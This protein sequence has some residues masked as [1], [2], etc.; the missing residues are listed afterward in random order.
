MIADNLAFIVPLCFGNHHF[1][2]GGGGIAVYARDKKLF[3]GLVAVGGVLHH[4]SES[5]QV[6]FG[7][8]GIGGLFW[9]LCI[10]EGV[11]EPATHIPYLA[12][13]H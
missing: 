7:V 11:V 13:R 3:L 12:D 1:L 6:R 5:L 4:I 10:V 9:I 2:S 8:F